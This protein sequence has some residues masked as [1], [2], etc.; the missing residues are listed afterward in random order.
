MGWPDVQHRARHPGSAYSTSAASL[1]PLPAPP[2]VARASLAPAPTLPRALPPQAI[3][4]R[5]RVQLQYSQS[6]IEKDQ[7]RKQVRGL[8]AE[9]DE[10]LTTLTSLEGAKALLEAQLERAQGG[11]CLK[12]SAVRRPRARV[13]RLG[14][15]R[16]RVG[17]R[18]DPLGSLS[19]ARE[20]AGSRR[21]RVGAGGPSPW[22]KDAL[23]WEGALAR[24]GD[25]A[26]P[27]ELSA[28]LGVGR[29][30]GKGLLS[31]W[32]CSWH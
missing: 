6:L 9:R 23:A 27:V 20:D 22:V 2:R 7:Y 25:C 11:S 28:G 19:W 26:G 1:V 4:S 10:L 3:Q 15:L 14:A 12:V 16:L 21:K 29:A 30:T 31:F 8:E 24:G 5:D 13:G 17:L 32:G 18:R